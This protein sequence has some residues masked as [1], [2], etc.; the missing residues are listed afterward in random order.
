MGWSSDS[1]CGREHFLFLLLCYRQSC[2]LNWHLLWC[3]CPGL[4]LIPGI[5]TI[6]DVHLCKNNFSPPVR[7]TYVTWGMQAT[8]CSNS[9]I[10]IRRQCTRS[11][12]CS[13]L[14]ALCQ[15]LGVD[16]VQGTTFPHACSLLLNCK[17]Y[18]TSFLDRN[19]QFHQIHGHTLCDKATLSSNQ[20]W[21]YSGLWL[22]SG[23]IL[24]YSGLIRTLIWHPLDRSVGRSCMFSVDRDAV[25]FFLIN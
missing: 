2:A 22:S 11:M 13:N 9:L 6:G 1:R 16:V 8:F 3:G 17:L 5:L 10:N 19:E 18:F 20:G 14:S 7:D 21:A 23:L 24:L 4:L 15:E 12:H 25:L